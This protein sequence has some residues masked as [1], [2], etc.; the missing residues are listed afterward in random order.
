MK[1]I[2]F[3]ENTNKPP[4]FNKTYWGQFK[5]DEI[6]KY[7]DFEQIFKNRDQFIKDYN[8]IKNIDK[9]KK[10][11]YNYFEYL[12]EQKIK[13]NHTEVYEDNENNYIIVNSPVNSG[14]EI[15]EFNKIYELYGFG[16]STYIK[17]ISKDEMK[18]VSSIKKTRKEYM[19][20]FYDKIKDEKY[21][22]DVCHGNY[23]YFNKP[24][25]L[26]TKRHLKFLGMVN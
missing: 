18:K 11:I 26:K 8:I 19:K 25:H 17:K 9:N 16:T 21:V 6:N 7:E 1:S 5:I 23:T 15:K 4:I 20:E 13:L 24:H 10:F 12:K 2:K 3:S 14:E 22:C